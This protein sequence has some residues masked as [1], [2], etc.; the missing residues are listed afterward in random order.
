MKY[1]LLSGLLLF[2]TYLFGQD[3]TDTTE[4]KGIILVAENAPEF[5]GGA[6]KL[7]EF[8]NSNLKYPKDAR[9]NEVEGKVVIS[10]V[11][12]RDGSIKSENIKI[13][14]SVYPSLDKEAIRVVKLMPNWIPA[15]HNGR[16]VR[17][18]SG[19]PI[20]FALQ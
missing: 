10:F 18:K 11:V 12:E 17:A 5:P 19:F 13:E 1:L 8:I 2:T 7:S 14:Q 6:D 20:T 9:K 15:N 16:S 4:T 3:S